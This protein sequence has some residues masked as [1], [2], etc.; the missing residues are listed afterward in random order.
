MSNKTQRKDMHMK[1]YHVNINAAPQQPSFTPFFM[2]IFAVATPKVVL[3]YSIKKVDDAIVFQV[4]EQ[5]QAITDFLKNNRFQ[6]SNGMIIAADRYPEIKD[7]TNHIYLRG[8]DD[9]R[10]LKLDVTRFVGKMQRDS[11]AAI[12]DAA[13]K[14]FVDFLSKRVKASYSP[15]YVY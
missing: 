2:P 4:K 13:L 12:I 8:T 1:V 6:A 9:S 14:E 5:S 10:N 15:V 7:S 11:K 3:E